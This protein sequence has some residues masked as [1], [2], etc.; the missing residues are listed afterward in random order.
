MLNLVYR[1]ALIVIL[2]AVT[3]LGGLLNPPY[4]EPRQNA[5]V[6][7]IE[8]LQ[9]ET[10]SKPNPYVHTEPHTAHLAS[11]DLIERDGQLYVPIRTYVEAH[12]GRLTYNRETTSVDITVDHVSF[13]LLLGEGIVMSN[14]R[15]LEGGYFVQNGTAYM[16]IETLSKLMIE[17]TASAA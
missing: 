12:Q 15:A 13:S 14:G 5:D 10:G 9:L 17:Y 4:I 2:G 7:S 8:K 1:N 6:P 3:L 11:S 16:S